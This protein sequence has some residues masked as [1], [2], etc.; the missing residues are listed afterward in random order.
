MVYIPF[1]SGLF[2]REILEINYPQLGGLSF[3]LSCRGR[4]NGT[5]DDGLI[6]CNP[7]RYPTTGLTPCLDMSKSSYLKT[8]L[9]F[10]PPLKWGVSMEDINECIINP[11][12]K[13][14]I[15]K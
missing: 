1:E 2:T 4:R 3:Q 15:H 6:D 8:A 9:R 7:E 14:I 10:L 5:E 12:L 13:S 11:Y